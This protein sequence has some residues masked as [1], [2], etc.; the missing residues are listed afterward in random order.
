MNVKDDFPILSRT[1]HG[2]KLIYLDNAATTQKPQAVI[3]ALAYFYSHTNA[4][5]HRGI[6]TLSEEATHQYEDARDAVARFINAKSREEIIFTRNATEGINLVA[7]AWARDHLYPGDE[8]IVSIMEHHS[9]FVPWQQ[10]AKDRGV[11]LKIIDINEEGRLK[12]QI[13]NKFEIRNSKL[14]DSLESAISERTKLIAVTHASN[15]LGMVNDIAAIVRIARPQGILVLV[16]GAQAAPHLTV[17]VQALG[18]DFYAFSSHKMLGPA[19][20]GVLYG[21]KEIL[22]KCRPFMTGGDMIK[23]VSVEKTEWNDLP[24]RFEAGTP[25][26]EGVIAF[27]VALEYLKKIGMELIQKH[28]EELGE[29][30]LTHLQSVSGMT[31]Y[32][33]RTMDHRLG[34]FSFNVKGVH[35]HDLATVLDEEGIAIRSGHHCANP[36]MLRLGISAAA[37]ASLYI[38]NTKEDVDALIKGIMKAKSIFS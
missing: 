33:P 28:E 15:V 17:D 21:R 38:Y 35:A 26:I 10:L 4:N 30:A 36:L 20:V 22:E 19:G 37:R 9:N 27:G 29:Y 7:Y 34:V 8:V 23:R 12:S 13:T 18:V 1:V 32:G 11:V 5:V 6:H 14:F 24:W 25:N 16:D 31:L 3:D 2:K